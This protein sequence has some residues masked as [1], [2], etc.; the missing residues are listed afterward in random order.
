M[1]CQTSASQNRPLSGSTCPPAE[2]V[3]R[4]RYPQCCSL[5]APLSSAN[6]L[7]IVWFM[8]QF[9]VRFLVWGGWGLQRPVCLWTGL[10]QL[11]RTSTRS[12]TTSC[13]IAGR[14]ARRRASGSTCPA[15]LLRRFWRACSG[16]LSTRSRSGPA[17]RPDTGRSAPPAPS[18]RCQMVRG[19]TKT[20]VWSCFWFLVFG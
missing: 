4:L 3:R 11:C 18:A 5:L 2:M 7:L 10:S 14:T 12:W 1:G 9:P 8:V 19:R 16:P 15:G 13:A 17:R 20:R 6:L